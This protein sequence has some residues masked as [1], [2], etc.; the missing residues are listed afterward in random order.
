MSTR[1]LTN[2]AHDVVPGKTTVLNALLQDKFSEVSMRRTTAGINFFRVSARN[3][4]SLA[5]DDT[6]SIQKSERWSSDETEE[7]R[8]AKS[9]LQEII[10]D[11]KGYNNEMFYYSITSQDPVFQSGCTLVFKPIK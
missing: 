2:H 6:A 9:T 10:A 7:P 11:N 1:A 4:E 8:K 3:K 5:D